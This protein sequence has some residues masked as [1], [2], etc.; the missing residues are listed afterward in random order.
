MVIPQPVLWLRHLHQFLFYNLKSNLAL[1]EGRK[2]EK[3]HLPVDHNL[4]CPTF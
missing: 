3:V 1:E 2:V 4:G